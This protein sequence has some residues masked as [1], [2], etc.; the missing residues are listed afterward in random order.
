MDERSFSWLVCI[1]KAWR[2]QT[3]KLLAPS[4]IDG[5]GSYPGRGRDFFLCHH[6]QTDPEDTPASHPT[7]TKWYGRQNAMLIPS[8]HSLSHIYERLSV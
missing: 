4:W 7:P 6:V 1:L 3:V 5:R 2:P 8:H